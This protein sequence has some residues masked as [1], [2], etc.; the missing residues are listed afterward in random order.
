M[1]TIKASAPGEIYFAPLGIVLPQHLFFAQ[2]LWHH[3]YHKY[4]LQHVIV[5]EKSKQVFKSGSVSGHRIKDS[6]NIMRQSLKVL[7][8]HQILSTKYPL[9][10]IHYS[11]VGTA[12]KIYT[13]FDRFCLWKWTADIDVSICKSLTIQGERKGR[14]TLL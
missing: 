13:I 8:Y 11:L 14:D 3:A 7:T 4:D 2:V 5:G 9:H 6:W 10:R 12:V 1:N